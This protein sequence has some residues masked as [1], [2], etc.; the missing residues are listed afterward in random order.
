MK[1]AI[2]LATIFSA[3]VVLGACRERAEP[4]K[5]GAMPAPTVTDVAK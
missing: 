2:V 4:M 1:K 5:V 3:A